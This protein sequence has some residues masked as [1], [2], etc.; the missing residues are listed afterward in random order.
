[1]NFRPLAVIALGILPA[2]LAQETPRPSGAKPIAPGQR[3]L[4]LGDSITYAGGYV[5]EFERWFATTPGAA[6][7]EVINVGLSSETVSGLSEED[8]AE[9]RFPR[10]DLH[11]RLARVLAAVRPQVVFA[12]YGMNDGIYLPLD[13]ARFARFC[14]GVAWLHATVEA[15]GARIIHLTPPVFDPNE[16]TKSYR[17]YDQVLARYAEWLLAQRARGWEVTDLH[18]P[19]RT[20]LDERRR[21]DPA[22]RF[23]PDGVH[24]GAEGHALMGAQVIGYF[25]PGATAPA[26]DPTRAA[27]FRRRMELRRDAWLTLT[28]HTRPGVAAGLPLEEATRQAAAITEQLRSKAP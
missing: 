27:L 16:K 12:C 19:M 4:F 23:A 1:M 22:F 24:P 7:V 3:V 26:D 21:S 13:E 11:E 5:V 14:E 28:K 6:G 20:Q 10:P 2:L 9:G 25:S 18:G 15:T 17:D 8:H